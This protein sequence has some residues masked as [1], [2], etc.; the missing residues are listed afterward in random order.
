M[1]DEVKDSLEAMASQLTEKRFAD[2]DETLHF[3]ALAIDESAC[4]SVRLVIG[5]L[6][7]FPGALEGVEGDRWIATAADVR[8]IDHFIEGLH[9]GD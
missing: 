3:L 5:E 4:A 6:P 1:F 2:V 9:W 8:V 7:R